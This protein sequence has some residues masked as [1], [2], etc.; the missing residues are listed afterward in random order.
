MLR[1]MLDIGHLQRTENG[2]LIIGNK[3]EYMVNNFEFYAMFEASDDY[4]VQSENGVIGTIAGGSAPGDTFVLAGQSWECVSVNEDT[5]E[6]YVKRAESAAQ[7]DWNS[8]AFAE[9][10]ETLLHKMRDI[11]DGQEEYKYLRGDC[12]D[13]LRQMRTFADEKGVTRQLVIE[14]EPEYFLIFPWLGSRRLTALTLYLAKMG[15]RCSIAPSAMTPVYLTAT[16]KVSREELFGAVMRFI[17][18]PPPAEELALPFNA[19]VRGKFNEFVPPELLRKQYVEDY[20]NQPFH[21]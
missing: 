16:G 12:L 20:L 10:D 7:A 18:S 5:K 14:T 8:A 17:N 19:Q 1:H 3:A 11:M 15:V 13:R 21:N 2:G 9:L 6:V 4:T